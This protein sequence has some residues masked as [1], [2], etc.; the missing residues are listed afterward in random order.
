MRRLL[1][2]CPLNIDADHSADRTSRRLMT[3]FLLICVTLFSAGCVRSAPL[4]AENSAPQPGSSAPQS[5]SSAS[6]AGNSAPREENSASPAPVI[7]D[8]GDAQYEAMVIQIEGLIG[9]DG[10]VAEISVAE[11]RALP[12]LDMETGYMRTTGLYENFRMAGPRLSDVIL[13]A[14]GNP[15]DYAGLGVIG[16]DNYYCLFSREVLDSTPDLILA[17]TI[18]G[19]P[20]LDA[21]EAPARAAVPGQFGPYWV[22]QIDKIVLYKEIPIKNIT[23]V[24]VFKNLTAGIT[25][26]E[27]E[28]YGSADHAI[29]LEQVFSRLDYVDSRAFFTMKSADG[30]KKN[31]AM[32]MVKSRYY[33]KIDGEDAPTNVA[34]YIKLGMNVQKIS[35]VSTNADAA[36]FPDMMAGYMSTVT[37]KGQTGIPLDELLYEVGVGTVRAADFDI[38]GTAGER[39]RVSGADLS[40][41]ILIPLPDGGGKVLWSDG[42]DYPDIEDLLRIRLAE[43]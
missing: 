43:G 13:Y 24:W 7:N 18:D 30:F 42:F 40:S 20:R 34:P 10:G 31:E 4:P 27:Y 32:N 17:V 39:V 15:D 9:L 5:G 19:E 23:S 16:R 28:Y 11:L 33:L 35:W 6:Q 36:V 22:K 38:L 2:S 1:T 25:P 37:I 41:A 14:G 26:I 12:Q 8:S 3:A 29:D 21:D